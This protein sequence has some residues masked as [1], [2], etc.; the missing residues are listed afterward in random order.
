MKERDQAL[1][2]VGLVLIFVVGTVFMLLAGSPSMKQGA[3]TIGESVANG[4]EDAL[5]PTADPNIELGINTYLSAWLPSRNIYPN[6]HAVERHGDDAWRTTDCYNRN[7][8]FHVVK[9]KFDNIHFLCQDDDGSVR[10]MILKQRGNSNV[11]DFD[12][13]FT[14]KDGT[15]KAVLDYVNRKIGAGKFT[16]PENAQV[17][18]DGVLAP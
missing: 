12:N 11:F 8:Y 13:A 17:Y 15:L 9:T 16:V 18:I 6:K 10:D 7:G 2:L 14:P 3:D 4:V 5:A 1:V